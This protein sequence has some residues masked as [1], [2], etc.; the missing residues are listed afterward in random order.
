MI[1]HKQT[2]LAL[3]L[4]AYIGTSSNAWVLPPLP[5]AGKI[6]SLTTS[7][8]SSAH[9]PL[10]PKVSST[11]LSGVLDNLTP[12]ESKIPE[13]LKD[14]IYRAEANT[15]AARDRG[16]RVALFGLIAFVGVVSAFFN[17]FLTELR[18]DDL[19]GPGID[20]SESAFAWATGNPV[21][22]F[23]FTNQ[24]GGGIALLLGAGSGLLAE[25]ELDSKRINAEKIY[26]ELER[27]RNEKTKPSASS[28]KKKKMQKA[29]KKRRS[30]KEKKRLGALS[31]VMAME[32]AVEEEGKT[33]VVEQSE[34]APEASTA[35]SAVAMI[36]TEAT[37]EE[38]SSNGGLFGGMKD[39]YEKADGMAASQ[40]LLLNKK[41]EDVGVVDKITDETGLKVIGKEAAAKLG[42]DKEKEG[43]SK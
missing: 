6:Q 10:Q 12:Y 30:G 39:L 22:A 7:S 34:A 8:T 20:L 23:I 43:E 40:A 14:E 13:E 42:S 37:E 3:L 26:E 15:P 9:Q 16:Q 31:E 32:N 1:H 19:D 28:K 18:T 35:D 11:A 25:A 33:V 27:R 5:Q 38:S 24:I 2:F 36:E 17:G 21:F 4:L 29:N 41:L